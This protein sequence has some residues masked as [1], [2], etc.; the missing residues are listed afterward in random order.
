[1]LGKTMVKADTRKQLV[2]T[3]LKGMEGKIDP[4]KCFD[5]RHGIRATHGGKTVELVICFHCSQFI[6]YV[7]S[8]EKGPLLLVNKSPE[9]SFDKV[10]KDADIPKAK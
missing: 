8:A 10:L 6:L 1:V 7:G 4:A 2:E 9:A 3:F 5:P